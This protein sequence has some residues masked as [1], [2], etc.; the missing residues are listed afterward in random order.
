MV[1]KVTLVPEEKLGIIILTNQEAGGAFQ[2]INYRLLDSFLGAPPTDWIAA[3]S[4]VLKAAR[5]N[6]AEVE[7]K[8]QTARDANS[9]PSLPLQKYAG[10]YRDPWYGDVT[11]ALEDGK[12]SMR[13]SHSPALVG[14]ME[15]YQYDT[16]IA[17]WQDRALGADAFVTFALKPDGTID[18]VKMQ[19]VSP[20]TDFSYDFQDL[21]LTPVAAGGK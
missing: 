20:L 11:I 1:S 17:R 15:H 5:A 2:A 4:Q 7:Q 19:P 6:A 16:F 8:F 13:F 3:Y 12:L 18:Q 9:K 21:L 10:T 14:P